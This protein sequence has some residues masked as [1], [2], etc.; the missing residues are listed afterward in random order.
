M[1]R[2]AAKMS[3]PV[4]QIILIPVSAKRSTYEFQE[5]LQNVINITATGL[6]IFKI[7]QPLYSLLLKSRRLQMTHAY[8]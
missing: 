1:G 8:S 4:N 7:R 5:F 2:A 3:W 6:N